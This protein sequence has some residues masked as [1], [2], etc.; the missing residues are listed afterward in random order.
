LLTLLFPIFF[1][2][3]FPFLYFNRYNICRY[4]G[5][6]GLR[7]E[8]PQKKKKER[9]KGKRKKKDRRIHASSRVARSDDNVSDRIKKKGE[10]ERAREKERE[11]E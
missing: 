3:F 11:M 6:A 7:R 9:K 4:S 5:D 2:P 8:F 1:S 10:S